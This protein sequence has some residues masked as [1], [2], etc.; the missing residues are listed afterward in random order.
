MALT[1][2]ENTYLSLADYKAWLDL[3]NYNYADFDDTQLE[4]SLV[5][6]SLDYID[7]NYKFKGQKLDESQLMSLPTDEVSISDIKSGAGQAAWQQLNGYLFVD[8]TTQS[9][10]GD[11]Q[12]ESKQLATL[13]KSVTYADG[14]AKGSTYSTTL[15]RRFLS[16]Y[17]IGGSTGSAIYRV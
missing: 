15:I 7:P 3:R 5:V 13:S 6:S 12:S 8:M 1:V 4:A 14:S 9:A 10:S 16:P 17:V 11:I 2:G